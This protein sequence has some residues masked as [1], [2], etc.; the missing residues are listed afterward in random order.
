MKYNDK[1]IIICMTFFMRITNLQALDL[2]MPE[3]DL[4][5]PIDAIHF[6][7]A[8]EFKGLEIV[9]LYFPKNG[10]AI[11]NDPLKTTNT[12]TFNFNNVTQDSTSESEDVIFI[13]SYI[14][15]DKT[16]AINLYGILE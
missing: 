1:K 2:I 6:T 16:I 11:I 14:P 4:L 12:C 7:P 3:Y 15:K 8:D 10:T 5:N 9:G 13:G